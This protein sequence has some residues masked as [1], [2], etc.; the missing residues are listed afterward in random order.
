MKDLDLS[1]FKK[2]SSDRDTSILKHPGGHEFRIAHKSLNDKLKKQLSELPMHGGKK[3]VQH[4][5]DA[6]T[7][8]PENDS[9]S[10]APGALTSAP[11]IAPAQQGIAPQ[12]SAPSNPYL[13]PSIDAAQA[14]IGAIGEQKRGE[15]MEAQAKGQLGQQQASLEKNYQ[16]QSYNA[17]EVYQ[18]NYAN[19]QN[20]RQMIQHDV[21]NGHVDP[22]RFIDN[23]STGKK[24]STGIGLILGGMG[25]GLTHG[26]NLAFQ[27]LSNNIDRDIESQKAEL[28]KNENL[29]ANNLAQTNDLR[30]AQGITKIQMNDMLSSNLR[31]EAD[32]AQ[33]PLVKA[34]AI[35]QIGLL[36]GQSAQIQ[37]QLA[38]TKAMMGQQGGQDQE[39]AFQQRMQFLRARGQGDFAKDTEAKHLAG[40]PGQ[41]S[42]E[43]TPENRKEWT[44][45][46]NLNDSYND[47]QAY[48]NNS[49]KAGSGWQNAHKAEGE[50]LSKRIELEIGQLEGLGRF[51]PEEAKRYRDM[52]PD[53]TGT[54][55]TGQDQAKLNKLMVEVK[56]HQNNFLVGAGF[57]P[58]A[59]ESDQSTNA[60]MS[61][62]K[63]NPNDPRSAEIL[64][65]LSAR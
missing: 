51:T 15:Q 64:K 7:V 55:F 26:P 53:L 44:H 1:K 20:E 62:A 32:K 16:Q 35:K 56:E 28:G 46:K 47:A 41:A 3:E 5:A 31:M 4:F 29:L 17:N 43:L 34:A 30:Q 6:G 8:L 42:N 10:L 38:M 49:S 2:V 50:S 36:D 19:L 13:Q 9:V 52:I 22:R 12:E 65:R 33:D 57:K 23:M 48:L 39:G 60:A 63:A 59:R 54:H 61:W 18:Q 24:I 14:Q 21:M 27:F 25:G 58:Q 45:L 11:S 40:V 37:S